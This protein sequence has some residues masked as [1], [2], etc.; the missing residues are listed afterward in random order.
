MTW[1]IGKRLIAG[2]AAVIAVAALLGGFSATQLVTL[3]TTALLITTDAIPGLTRINRARAE[4]LE[5]AGLMAEHLLAATETERSAVEKQ[6]SERTQRHDAA[7]KDYEATIQT[8][9]DRELFNALGPAWENVR[10]VWTETL[11]P[12]SRAG[13]LDEASRTFRANMAPANAAYQAALTPLVALNEENGKAYGDQID[14]GVN[15]GIWAISFGVLI[16]VGLGSGLGWFIVR[17]INRVL[18]A[19]VG[20]M[21]SGTQQ[22]ASASN[23][24]AT[25]AQAL[26]QGATEQAASL[27]ETSAS[28]EEM[29]SMTRKNADN[30]QTAAGLMAGVDSRVQESNR[31]LGDMVTA[32]TGIQESSQQVAKIIKTIDEIAFQTNILA[33][34]AAVEAARAGE[35]GMGFAVVADE[36]RN[37][38]QRSA[39]AARDTAGLIEE[40]I[41]KAQDGTRRVEQAVAA[42]AAITESVVA[43]KTMVEEVS[44]A[45][46]QQTQGIDQVSQAIAQMEKVTQTTAATAEESAA[47]S[48]ELNAQADTA[49]DVVNR[50][51]A[52]I[53]GGA[54]HPTT[55]RP[56][57]PA[58]SP[59]L[60]LAS[61]RTLAPTGTHGRF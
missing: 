47:A 39:Q 29:A 16:A 1:T 3:R 41:T 35:A 10:R 31:T 5:N 45:S 37:L 53:G 36:V 34:N 46:R 51:Q 17:G 40:S 42:I 57:R 15:Y 54:A 61:T 6:I 55:A 14:A 18:S 30:S 43:V 12:L 20:E 22:V 13:K 58:A 48:E 56:S 33:L 7:I 9:R 52:L 2:F 28:M 27:E 25:S 32:M 11:L 19:A 44:D 21:T 4:S 60:R 24:V 8:D 38:A 26:S 50:L 59:A 49:M 23:Q